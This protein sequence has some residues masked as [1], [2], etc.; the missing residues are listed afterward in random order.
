MTS[1]SV[2]PLFFSFLLSSAHLPHTESLRN[3]THYKNS[4][5]MA[6]CDN[7]LNFCAGRAQCIGQNYR[8]LNCLIKR[9]LIGPIWSFP[10]KLFWILYP[11]QF[12]VTGYSPISHET[13]AFLFFSLYVL[14]RAAF[15]HCVERVQHHSH[16]FTTGYSSKAVK[17]SLSRV[18]HSQYSRILPAAELQVFRK[19]ICPCSWNCGFTVV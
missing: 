10:I 3:T 1:F 7:S 8:Q 9:I 16:H 14:I 17:G 13:F 4:P 18:L 12:Y 15:C 11:M 5:L 6:C 2:Y 19:H